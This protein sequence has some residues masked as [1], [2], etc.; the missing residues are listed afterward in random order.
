MTGFLIPLKP[1]WFFECR[2]SERVGKNIGLSY[3]NSSRRRRG[4][5]GL[6][7][8]HGRA[9]GRGRNIGRKASRRGDHGVAGGEHRCVAPAFL[10]QRQSCSHRPVG[11]QNFE[12]CIPED[13][14]DL[15]RHE[16]F[17]FDNT[18]LGAGAP[19]STE[20]GPRLGRGHRAGSFDDPCSGAV[21]APRQPCLEEIEFDLGVQAALGQGANDGRTKPLPRWRRDR[22]PALFAPAYGEG[23]AAC[24]VAPQPI[25][26]RPSE[27]D[28]AP[29]LPALVASSW[30]AMP[31][32]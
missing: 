13:L 31:R 8:H 10:N 28:S 19:G 32:V 18:H 30:I 29:Y 26:M 7:L 20:F 2:E 4:G 23:F 21:Q 25:A 6:R 14:R 11:T 27:T 3:A 15:H 5:H 9:C 17:I 1:I 24:A 16:S 12:I 22:R